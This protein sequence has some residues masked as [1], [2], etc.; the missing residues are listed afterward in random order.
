VKGFVVTMLVVTACYR[1][2][3]EANCAATCNAQLG[4]RACP[5]GLVCGT[6]GRCAAPGVTCLEDGGVVIDDGMEQDATV[7]VDGGGF[8]YGTPPIRPCFQNEPT[9]TVNLGGTD[10]VLQCDSPPQR[11]IVQIGGINVCMIAAS[12]IHISTT[13]HTEGANPLLLVG[14]DRV[15]VDQGQVLDVSSAT[16]GS[17]IGAGAD[18]TVCADVT[19]AGS[20]QGGVGGS[21]V[22]L[23]GSGG[24]GNP[25]GNNTLSAAFHGGCPGGFGSGSVA[26]GHGGGAVHIIGENAI[27]IRGQ[28]RATGA[29]GHGGPNAAKGGGGGGSGGYIGLDSGHID[30]LANVLALGGGGGG[31]ADSAQVA[32]G[33]DGIGGGDGGMGANGATGGAG[34]TTGIGG[35]GL[36]SMT[37]DSGGGGGGGS[38]GVIKILR[39]LP[40]DCGAACRPAAQ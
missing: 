14:V 22:A 20:D 31:G 36:P 23:G 37:G 2:S 39:T 21:F 3:Q 11:Q 17:L 9:G 27:E 34:G 32:D 7:L 40:A 15:I 24:N 19:G 4:E 6:T 33:T 29:G 25:I 38:V 35:D 12:I 28:I 26:P 13:G 8:C 18:P 16:N 1:P 10:T 5:S 30:F